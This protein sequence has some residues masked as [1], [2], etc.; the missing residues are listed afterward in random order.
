[1]ITSPGAGTRSGLGWQVLILPYIE[2]S[3]VSEEA[4]K[5]Y[6]VATFP[7]AIRRGHECVEFHATADVPLP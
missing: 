3:T 5:Q 4:L 6:T 1:M 7:D 2:E